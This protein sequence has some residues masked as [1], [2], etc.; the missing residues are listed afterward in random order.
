MTKNLASFFSPKSIAVVGASNTPGKVGNIVFQ[1]IVSSTF[2]GN[3]YPINNTE[4]EVLGKK[5]FSNLKEVPEKLDLIVLAVPATVCLT[6]LPE[7]ESL[8]IQNVICLAAGFKEIGQ[9]GLENEKKL[10]DILASKKLNVLGP[11]CFGFINQNLDLN[12]T[13]GPSFKKK[14]KLKI[15][16]QSG[17]IIS[18][19]TDFANLQGFG[20]SEVIT[21]GNKADINENDVLDYFLSQNL[22]LDNC[23]GIGFYLESL[24]NGKDFISKIKKLTQVVPIFILK[25]GK[26]PETSNALKSHT[27]SLIGEYDVFEQILEDSG[28]IVCNSLSN[29][30]NYAKFFGIST[31]KIES[32]EIMILSNAGGPSVLAVDELYLHNFR[33]SKLSSENISKLKEVLPISASFSNPLDLVGDANSERLSKTLDVLVKDESLKNFIIILT[34]QNSTDF[35]KIV[36]ILENLKKSQRNVYAVLLGGVVVTKFSYILNT[37]GIPTFEYFEDLILILENTLN[38]KQEILTENLSFYEKRLNENTESGKKFSEW[39]QTYITSNVASLKNKRAETFMESFGIKFPESIECETDL[40]ALEFAKKVNYPVVLKASEEGLIHKKDA[41]GLKANID[42]DEE[43]KAEF[44]LMKSKFKTIQ[45]QKQVSSGLEIIVGYRNDPTFGKII[46]IGAGGQFIDIIKDKNIT[47]IPAS[48]EKLS[49]LIQKSKIYPVIKKENINEEMLVSIIND[50]QVL[51]SYAKPESEIEINPLIL[52]RDDITPVDVKIMFKTNGKNES[53]ASKI[54]N[55]FKEATVIKNDN[56]SAKFRHLVLE[57]K[58]S[59]DFIP[60]QYL[61]FKVADKTYRSYSIACIKKDNQFELLV[62]TKP[63]GPGSKYFESVKVGETV[64]FMGPFGTFSLK[65]PV[66]DMDLLFFVTG[67]GITPLKAIIDHALFERKLPNRIK[68]YFGLTHD[69]EIFWK[70]YFEDLTKKFPNFSIEYA[71]HNPSESWQGYKGYVTGLL[72]RDYKSCE[73]VSA[74]LCGHKNMM[75]SV[76]KML[77]EKGCA[78][79]KIYIERYS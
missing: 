41:Q 55:P 16:T 47:A 56:V 65:E 2:S 28:A 63:Q 26:F 12:L 14:S 76:T 24:V 34:P 39:S 32:N 4:K 59:W 53:S 20:V 61:N 38:H 57:C 64:T 69:S 25:P 52:T 48:L 7:I 22:S 17:A 44:N 43:L 67:S 3:I 73:K 71:M 13:F 40:E 68:L 35:D 50:F 27:G 72:D 5:S 9:A 66:K 78:K 10:Q 1:N 31:S 79:D 23:S 70:D 75:E 49:H 18:A 29:F 46:Q 74:Y 45:V 30:F 54:K 58:S 42:S 19:L 77:L 11:N 60:G 36:L 21:L 33:L 62:D 37:K 51:C 15:V 6:L 8:G